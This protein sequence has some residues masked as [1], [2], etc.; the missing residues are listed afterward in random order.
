M[1]EPLE[2]MVVLDFSSGRAGAIATMVMSDFGAEVIKV[3]PPEG[4]PYRAFPQALLWNRGKKSVTLDLQT[5]EGRENARRLIGRADVVVESFRPGEADAQGIGYQEVSAQRPDL[6][7]CS[8]TA[9]GPKGPYA[10]YKPYEGIVS[11]K[12]GRFTAFTGQD[13][14]PSPYFAAVQVA[15]HSTAMAAVRGILSAL[16]VRDKTGLGQKVETSLIQGVTPFDVISWL[17]W[18]M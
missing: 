3:E 5:T 4:D 11:A 2:N 10:H 1:T 8:I 7:Y 14:G 12:V 9:F 16:I 18:Q 6:V 13:G 17:I 15:N